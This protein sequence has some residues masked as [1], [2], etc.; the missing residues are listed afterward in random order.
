[1]QACEKWPFQDEPS[2]SGQ[3][4]YE[5]FQQEASLSNLLEITCCLTKHIFVTCTQLY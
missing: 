2:S 1:M 3:R 4:T 5:M